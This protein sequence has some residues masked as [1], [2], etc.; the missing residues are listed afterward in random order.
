MS[1]L[2]RGNTPGGPRSWTGS[3][4]QN[5]RDLTGLLYMRNR[6]Y[7]PKTGRFTQEDPIGL[8]G[9][10]NT[11]GFADGDPV[12]YTDPYGLAAGDGCDP[13]GSCMTTW[14]IRGAVAG[15]VVGAAAGV[16]V[17]AP[18]GEIAAPV[19]VPTLAVGGAAVGV[20]GGAV[21][22][23]GVEV[24]ESRAFRKFIAHSL[25]I[26]GS[27]TGAAGPGPAPDGDPEQPKRGPP[28]V[29]YGDHGKPPPPPRNPG[30]RLPAGAP[31]G[32]R[33]PQPACPNIRPEPKD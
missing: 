31:T 1:H 5:K 2:L 22:G 33:G 28:V 24:S 11:Y 14:A 17:A 6:Y 30:V 9:G 12:S 25:D 29:P 10:L 7:D 3:L 19:T 13:P 27:I 23:L 21:Y 32:A 26:F 20:I 16:L 18:T 8:A 15:G 4:I